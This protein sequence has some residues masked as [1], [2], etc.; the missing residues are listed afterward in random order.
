MT[1][2]TSVRDHWGS[3]KLANHTIASK[4]QEC[5]QTQC[6][7]G[8]SKNIKE[9]KYNVCQGYSLVCYPYLLP[10]PL[11]KYQGYLNFHKSAIVQAAKPLEACF[12]FPI[13]FVGDVVKQ[14]FKSLQ[15]T[16]SVAGS[17]HSK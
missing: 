12:V 13:F 3:E 2:S 17:D 7:C 10:S 1:H 5:V 8:L 9:E 16:A 11:S 6:E 14:R 15:C 4:T